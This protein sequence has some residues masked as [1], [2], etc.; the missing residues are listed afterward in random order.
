MNGDTYCAWEISYFARVNFYV[1]SFNVAPKENNYWRR[2]NYDFVGLQRFPRYF[3]E[4]A[5]TSMYS[6]TNLYSY[7]NEGD[8]LSNCSNGMW[9]LL[10]QAKNDFKYLFPSQVESDIIFRL[11]A[12]DVEEKQGLDTHSHFY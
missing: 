12:A 8:A 4:I 1:F 7:T 3:H 5:G 11:H 2:N 10:Y 9:N 6:Y